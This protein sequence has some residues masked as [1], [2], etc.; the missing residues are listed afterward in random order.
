MSYVACQKYAGHSVNINFN[1]LLMR[2]DKV[3]HSKHLKRTHFIHYSFPPR[4]SDYSKEEE[5]E[6]KTVDIGDHA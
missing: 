4:Y 5:E 2:S 6:E 3:I 1:L